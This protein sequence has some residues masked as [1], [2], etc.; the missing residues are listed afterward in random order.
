MTT[1]VVDQVPVAQLIEDLAVYPRHSV[2]GA[3]VAGIARAIE[4]GADMPPIIAEQGTGRVV[5]G[6][7]RR[8]AFRKVHGDQ[9][10]VPVEWRT[11]ASA[12]DLLADAVSLNSSHGRPLD[13]QDRTRAALMLEK[14]GVAPQRIAVVLRTTEAHVGKLLVRIVQVKDEQTGRV[15]RQPAKPVVRPAA[16]SVEPRT[17]NRAQYEVHASSSGLRT[18]QTVTQLARELRSGLV[19]VANTPGLREKLADLR[20]AIDSVL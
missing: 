6:F 20:T 7:H 19:D 3:H 10:V 5:D 14:A 16:G 8:R 9:V 2:D 11:Y 18:A 13:A 17:I 1:P 4:A 15:E 12:A